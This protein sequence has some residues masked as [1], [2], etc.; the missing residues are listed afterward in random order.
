MFSKYYLSRAKISFGTFIF[1]ALQNKYFS[2]HGIQN[3]KVCEDQ[4]R[5]NWHIVPKKLIM[6]SYFSSYVR[7]MWQLV[8]IMNNMSSEKLFALDQL[9][10]WI[11]LFY[12]RKCNKLDLSC[13]CFIHVILYTGTHKETLLLPLS[14]L[15]D[16]WI[17]NT[18]KFLWRMADV[19]F[20]NCNDV[21]MCKWQP[22]L[23][24][25]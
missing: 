12:N 19:L 4:T 9:K 25:Q 5:V 2:K 14:N 18:I 17:M 3:K 6:P 7:W 22:F 23:K 24:L 1:V 8:R 11:F 21:Y 15:L 16:L 10:F 20:L 13:L